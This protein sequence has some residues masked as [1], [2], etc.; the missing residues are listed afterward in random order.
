[1]FDVFKWS[2]AGVSL[3]AVIMNIRKDR[4]CFVL[5]IG[6]NACWASVDLWYGIWPQAA[7]QALYGALAVWGVW[8]WRKQK[9]PLRVDPE[10]SV[11]KVPEV[12]DVI[13]DH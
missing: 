6:T 4:R 8:S 12:V 2:L 10:R 1:M 5:W 3:L 13:P 7:L 9:R 11:A